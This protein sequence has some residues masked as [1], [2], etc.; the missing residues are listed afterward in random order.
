MA[1]AAAAA[2]IGWVVLNRH[3]DYLA[4]LRKTNRVPIFAL[5]S[6]NLEVGRLQAR[7]LAALLPT[8]GSALYIQGPSDSGTAKLRTDGMLE[9]KSTGVQLK[10]MKAQWTEASAYKA[11]NAWLRLST[12]QQSHIDLIAAHNDAMVMGARKAFQEIPEQNARERWLALPYV[13]CDGVRST[14]QA[15]VRSGVLAATVVT[16]PL[17]GQALEM[18]VTSLQ[19]GVTPPELTMVAPSSFPKLEVLVSRSQQA[20]AAT[21]SKF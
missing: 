16:P 19:T 11:I 1:R 4:A 2:G 7:Q 8:G 13:G 3:A 21:A 6:D 10:M 12:S 15:L 9:M 18:L 17:A 14:G 5:N 20:R